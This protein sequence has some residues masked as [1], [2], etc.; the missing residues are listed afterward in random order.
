RI[1]LLQAD[2]G[3]ERVRPLADQHDVG[4][5]L[6]HGAGGGD[7]VAGGGQAGDGAGGAVGPVHDRRIKL[8]AAGGG[9]DGPAS[10]VEQRIVFHHLDRRLDRVQRGPAGGQYGR[11]GLQRRVQGGAIG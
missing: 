7:G 8:V 10:G 2:R 3:G 11:T 6:H 1:N 9:E 5:L 4:R